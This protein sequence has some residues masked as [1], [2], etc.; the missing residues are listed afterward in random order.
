MRSLLVTL[1]LLVLTTLPN[2]AQAASSTAAPFEEQVRLIDS[3]SQYVERIDMARLLIVKS[4]V[5][6][7]IENLAANAQGGKKEITFQ[8]LRLIQNL[9]I[10]YRFSQVFFGW[11]EPR[12]ITSI[13][14]ES[15]A[16]ELARLKLLSDSIQSE[17]GYDD[18][19][20]TQIT[21]TTFR[22]MQR[23][24]KQLEDLPL[25][26]A[27]K[28]ELRALWAP[29]GAAI[30]SAEAAGGDRRKVYEPAMAAIERVRA[31]YPNFNQVSASQSGFAMILELQGLT[32]FYAEFAQA[33]E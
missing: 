8:T 2:P 3:V 17:F 7:V 25:D 33:D 32:E 30:A 12:A 21:A 26:P 28:K 27:F 16:A 23:L 6:A 31:L 1:T 15:S 22:Q 18:S 9:I 24:L 20:Y 5:K 4:A 13:Y 14:T 19:P 10:Q 29:I 11:S